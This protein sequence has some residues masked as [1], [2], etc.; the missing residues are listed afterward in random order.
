MQNPGARIPSPLHTQHDLDSGSLTMKSVVAH[1]M[2]EPGVYRGTF[3]IGDR[4][5]STFLI[6][7]S[8][9]DDPLQVMIDA[10]ELQLLARNAPPDGIARRVR[11]RKGGFLVLHV[12]AGEGGH[13]ATLIGSET[14][15]GWDSR[16]L[17]RGDIFSAIPLRPGMYTLA[18]SLDQ[19]SPAAAVTVIYPDPRHVSHD[20]ARSRPLYLHYDRHG[21]SVRT[22]ELQPGQG[23]VIT[24][25]ELARFNLTLQRPDDGPPDLARWREEQHALL[26]RSIRSKRKTT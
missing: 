24:V 5:V 7:V 19:R 6:E 25:K 1:P 11:I 3:A 22:I 23:I 17:E 21:F 4:S 18:N 15:G 8:D 10:H 26:M 20:L 16:R 9:S 2:V 12:T 13:H 14:R